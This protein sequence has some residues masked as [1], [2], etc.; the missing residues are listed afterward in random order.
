MADSSLAAVTVR[1]QRMDEGDAGALL[2]WQMGMAAVPIVRVMAAAA[3]RRGVS[4]LTA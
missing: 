4:V 2:D 3:G 1:F